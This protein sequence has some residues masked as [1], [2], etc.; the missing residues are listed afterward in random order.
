[1]PNSLKARLK[2]LVYQGI[3]S[4]EDLDRII[5]VSKDATNGDAIKAL[6]PDVKCKNEEE[7]YDVETSLCFK[8]TFSGYWWNQNYSGEAWKR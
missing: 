4:Q 1:M 8:K 7:G 3:L 6:F 5:V 2:K